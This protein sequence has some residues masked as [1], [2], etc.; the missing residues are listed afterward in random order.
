[1][2]AG[3]HVCWNYLTVR[4]ADIPAVTQL[5]A[6]HGRCAHRLQEQATQPRLPLLLTYSPLLTGVSM[7]QWRNECKKLGCT[8]GQK[9]TMPAKKPLLDNKKKR[10]GSTEGA[11]EVMRS[12]G[13]RAIVLLLLYDR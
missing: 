8:P 1:M 10:A 6:E 9:P 4:C 13:P 7:T 11:A 12:I 3:E 5:L 2:F